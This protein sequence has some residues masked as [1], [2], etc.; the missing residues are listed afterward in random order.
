MHIWIV[1]IWLDGKWKPTVGSGLTREDA[2]QELRRWKQ[3]CLN[4][5]F[6]LQK[7]IPVAKLW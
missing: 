2:R 3:K 5:K 7:Y 6:R 4:D 1:E